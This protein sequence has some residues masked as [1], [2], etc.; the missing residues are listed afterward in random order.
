M[1]RPIAACLATALPLLSFIAAPAVAATDVD[2]GDLVRAMSLDEKLALVRGAND[3]LPS[4]AAGYLPGVPRLGIPP[5]R[6]ADGPAG[7]EARADATALPSPE[8]LAAAF[9]PRL[10]ERYGGVLGHEARAL[11][12]DVVLA[13]H[14]NLPRVPWFHRV[15]DELGEDPLVAATIGAG[16]IRGIQAEGAMAMVKHLAANDQFH[17]Q[18]LAD[19]R[20]SERALAEIHLPPFEAAVRE[21][22]VASVMCAYNRVNGPFSCAQRDLMTTFLR[23]RWGFGG[24]VTS[25][26]D[27]ARS[28]A[29]E[30]GLDVEMPGTSSPSWYGRLALRGSDPRAGQRLDRAVGRVLGEMKRFGLL[31]GASP[32][33]GRAVVPPRPALDREKSAVVA[34]EVAV[35]GAVLLKNEA[36]FLPLPEDAGRRPGGVLVIGPTA[37]R[38]AAGAGVERAFGFRDREVAPFEAL[39]ARLGPGATIEH[40]VG[41]DL[42]GETIPARALAWD[43]QEENAPIQASTGGDDEHG[44]VRMPTE[45][46]DGPAEIDPVIDH[47]GDRSLP[48]GSDWTWAGLL[49]PPTS[50][51]YDLI[52][53]S[54][55]GSVRLQVGERVASSARIGANGGLA[56][57]WTGIVPSH[58]GL[59][60]VSMRVKLVAGHRYQIR[61][62]AIAQA[63][64]PLQV[65]FAWVTPE[66]RRRALDAAVAAA[67][68]ASRVIVFA[69][70]GGQPPD[71]DRLALPTDQDELISAVAA[72][73][74]ETAVVLATGRPVTMPW[75]GAVRAV[76]LGWYP[77]QEGGWALADLLTGRAEPGGRLP[78]TFPARDDQTLDAGR[79]ERYLGVDDVVAYSEG[80]FV[81]Y[82][83]Y[84]EVGE[85][86]L[87]PFGHG[88]SYG[89][90]EWRDA[91]VVPAGD[92]FDAAVTVVN[93]G[94]RPTSDVVQVYLERPQATPSDLPMPPRALAAFARVDDLA[95]GESRRVT[96][97]LDRRRFEAWSEREHGWR[98]VPGARTVAFAA[99][100]REIRARLPVTPTP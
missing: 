19:F 51:T 18:D 70:D 46:A 65:R 45:D 53:E 75:L 78:L 77:G 68:T 52:V 31:G 9:D 23:D 67:K 37:D 24:F 32:W 72:A 28:Q 35:R 94:E 15:K 6:T 86:P 16:E 83:W 97:H 93:T 79:P 64:S 88:L 74:P 76:L 38:L 43:D 73:N 29:F 54:A 26:W 61:I 71:R 33:R 25:D 7:I 48:P 60:L 56:R 14:V 5:L 41:I 49:T 95:V 90:V 80:V 4:G 58:D 57:P 22:G 12:M 27:A 21:A 69:H 98:L 66:L 30:A 20:I 8:A 50:G 40:R 63:D 13:P 10:A 100:S 81:G 39:R 89:R 36:G 96:M 55:G 3:P 99:S 62:R 17:L 2:I 82:R 87:F 11:G 47:T 92:G 84:D 44:F 1:P 42:D 59:D 34:R 91:T 85:T